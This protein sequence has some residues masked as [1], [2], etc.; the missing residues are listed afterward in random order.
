MGL[1]ELPAQDGST[2]NEPV[3]GDKTKTMSLESLQ[4]SCQ[5]PC[6]RFYQHNSKVSHRNLSHK[7]NKQQ[8]TI[9]ILH[10]QHIST[11]Q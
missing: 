2:E 11:V 5:S 4:K 7:A 8:S 10:L 6:V 1:W 3:V 9:G